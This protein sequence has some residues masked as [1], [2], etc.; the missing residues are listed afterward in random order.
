ML[1]VDNA[2]KTWVAPDGTVA[3]VLY[4]Q[5]VPE[6]A[7]WGM[8]CWKLADGTLIPHGKTEPWVPGPE[9]V[10]DRDEPVNVTEGVQ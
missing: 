7:G 4:L 5:R 8:L 9:W 6:L 3:K 10:L 1:V 2:G